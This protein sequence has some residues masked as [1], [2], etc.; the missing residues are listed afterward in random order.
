[1]NP[2]QP[3]EGVQQPSYMKLNSFH[4][5]EKVIDINNIELNQFKEFFMTDKLLQI[6]G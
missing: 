6:V 3:G 1:M 4:P 2:V 5:T